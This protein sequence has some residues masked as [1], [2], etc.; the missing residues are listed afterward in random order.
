MPLSIQTNV[1][2]LIAQENLRVNNNFQSQTIQ[3]LT[4]GFRINQSGDDAAGLAIANKFRS[5][6]S[7]LS[8]GVRNANDGVS[9]LQ[10]ID[11][12]MNN[13]SK[14]LD[15][16]KT[17]ATQ[18]ASD[19]FTGDRNALNSEYQTLV[20][21]I[22][23]QAQSIG[24][25]QGGTFAK[26]LSVFIG[27]GGGVSPE[28]MLANGVITVDLSNSM[29][30]AGTLGL[31][32]VQAVS[33]SSYDLGAASTTSVQAIVNDRGNGAGAGAPVTDTQFTFFGAGYSNDS[34]GSNNGVQIDVN[35][36]GVA[37]TVGL[38][39]AINAAI[40]AQENQPTG[41]AANFKAADISA[42]IVTDSSGNQKLAFQS[43]NAAFLVQADDRVAN[44]LIGNFAGDG[45][46]VATGREMGTRVDARTGA[47]AIGTWDFSGIDAATFVITG[48]GLTSP[49][50]VV[51][52]TDASGL[53]DLAA[54]AA[55]LT[56]ALGVTGLTVTSNAGTMRFTSTAGAISV[57]VSG[58]SAALTALGMD[59]TATAN[60]TESSAGTT[61]SDFVAGG[62][63]Q[64][65]SAGV[66]KNFTFAAVTAG[67]Q[68]VTVTASDTGGASHAKTVALANGGTGATLAAAV[69][70]I[71][72]AVQK[73]ND[74]TLQQITAVA[75]TEGGVQKINFISTVT[76][77]RVTVAAATGGLSDASGSQ[78]TTSA[79][80]QVGSGA[81]ADIGSAAGAKTAVSALTTA[82][83]TLGSAQAAVGKGQNQLSYAI[84]LANSQISN[85]SAAQAQIRDADVAAEA[86][87]L[88]KAQVL[89]Q[90]SL[91]AMAQAN[92]APQAV[93]SLLKG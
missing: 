8:Q 64:I 10:I 54:G 87:N 24:L 72:D 36:N 9:Q 21:E 80:V 41:A 25:N 46:S 20:Q 63:Y 57:S 51:Y 75:V 74:S 66:T 86:A 52:N 35:L 18:S 79:A 61:Y 4:S 78:G 89:L 90:A 49:K 91:A 12:G 17:L 43:S 38:V 15:R 59:A 68:S 93:L 37:D 11:G 77:F 56:T 55:A 53:A 81:A 19:S 60:G 2:S 45:T 88:T 26:S 13:I 92:S 5:D 69:A 85:F 39:A 70:A 47:G 71:N 44:A 34:G 48:A 84:G 73:S 76:D 50:T 67:S 29:V 31:K 28:A 42:T 83:K 33:S 62:S 30:D 27:G 16:L 65:G 40:D 58:S 3:R 7:E 14:M 22:D 6:I 32:G 23:R 1:N 82:I